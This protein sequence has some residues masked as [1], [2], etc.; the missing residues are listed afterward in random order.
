MSVPGG[1]PPMHYQQPPGGGYPPGVS[2][3]SS[4]QDPA[5]LAAIMLC[6]AAVLIF[7]GLISKSWL[8]FSAGGMDGRGYVAPL[9]AQICTKELCVQQSL[10]GLLSMFALVGLLTGFA[11]AAAAGMYGVMTIIGLRQRIPLPPRFGQFV[12]YAGAGSLGAFAVYVYYEG[13]MD[14]RPGWG[15][16]V[17]GGGMA[18]AIFGIRKL[19]PFMSDVGH[20]RPPQFAGGYGAPPYGHGAPQY[21]PQPYPP[22]PY[23]PQPYLQQ[24]QQ[25]GYGGWP[26]S[27]G[28]PPPQQ[29]QGFAPPQQQ[30]FVRPQP[31]MPAQQQ[32]SGGW[33]GSA[34]APSPPQQGGHAQPPQGFGATMPGG[35]APQQGYAP[36]QQGPGGWPAHAGAPAPPQG[37]GSAPP[38]YGAPHAQHVEQPPAQ[39]MGPPPAPTCPRCGKPGS[40]F[41]E[42]YRRWF[43]ERDQCYL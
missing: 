43:C 42:Q 29:P 1:A 3:P 12:F 20:A 31:G 33:P 15:V 37:Y 32:G 13:G 16:F 39:P 21:P 8:S 35:Y 25:Q 40:K 5:V 38:G 36:P 14:I 23:P 2:K 30:G 24:Q 11:S 7:V 6:A 4:Q 19:M 17:G 34:G 41:D 10:T 22:Q 18:L 26:A 9:G 28:A 27:A